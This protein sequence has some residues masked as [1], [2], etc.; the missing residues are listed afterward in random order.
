MMPSLKP[1]LVSLIFNFPCSPTFGALPS[2]C[3]FRLSKSLCELFKQTA[4]AITP[5][6]RLPVNAIIRTNGVIRQPQPLASA[7]QTDAPHQAV[8]GPFRTIITT[9]ET[10]TATQLIRRLLIMR[11]REMIVGR[12]KKLLRGES[13]IMVREQFS[14]QRSLRPGKQI[15]EWRI[16]ADL[17]LKRVTSRMLTQV[18]WTFFS[19]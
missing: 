15:Y 12:Q 18:I 10:K 13:D 17:S 9:R 19:S 8:D 5:V 16:N 7:S 3:P 2:S 4:S 11:W 1:A 14:F 6:Q